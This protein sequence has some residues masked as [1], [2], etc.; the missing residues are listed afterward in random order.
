MERATVRLGAAGA[1]A[2]LPAPPPRPAPVEAREAVD[3]AEDPAT[4]ARDMDRAAVE[5]RLGDEIPRILAE[6]TVH[7]VTED[8]R[9]SGVLLSRV[10]AGSLL[11]DA[12]LRA[13]D[14]L[15]HVNGVPID[16]LATLAGLWGRL[17]NETDL[18]AVV[19][20]G[21]RPVALSVTLR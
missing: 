20:R 13:G 14:I 8:G 10:P 18:R 9:V 1:L 2:S 11:T 12:G 5:R 15:T 6:T 16:G 19:L 4:P 17:Q 3:A 21:G 7:P